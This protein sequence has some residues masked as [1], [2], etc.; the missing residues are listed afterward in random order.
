MPQLVVRALG[1]LS[2]VVK[3]GSHRQLFESQQTLEDFCRL[4]VLPNITIRPHEEEMFEDDPMEFIRQ[5]L[6]ASTEHDT[7][8]AAATEFTRALMQQFEQQVTTIIGSH[9]ERFLQLYSTN[10]AS[11]WRAKDTA[12]YL[13]TSI[14]SRGSTQHGGVTSVNSLIDVVDWFSRNIFADLQA[15]SSAVNPIL[16]ADAIKFL[17]TFRNQLTKD[18]LISVLPLLMQHLKADNYV[19]YSFAAI[20][21]ERI[22]FIKQNNL[23]L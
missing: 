3:M 1:F 16:Q 15:D 10:P 12:I 8:R 17:Y 7:R 19:I 23:M 2:V 14:A 5:D 22:L 11:E 20:T 6:E 18:Q 9:I 21:I 4:I 13:L